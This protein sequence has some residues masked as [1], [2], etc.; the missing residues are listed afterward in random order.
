MGAYVL[1]GPFDSANPN[2]TFGTPVSLG[3]LLVACFIGNTAA[4]TTVTDNLGNV[5]VKAVENPG[6]VRGAIIAYAVVTVPGTCTVTLNGSANPTGTTAVEIAGATALDQ[7]CQASG[8]STAV[9]CG[10]LNT[11]FPGVI[12]ACAYCNGTASAG[13]GGSWVFLSTL[14]GNLFETLSLAPPG[15]YVIT[16]TSSPTG[17]Y[18][19]AAANFYAPST[20][21]VQCAALGW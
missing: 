3:H 12:V 8:S 16:G 17:E 21:T 5:W 4:G 18:D 1:N 20:E 13:T 14:K 2:V 19:G 10:T 11:R 7:T 9:Q 15:Q 6:I